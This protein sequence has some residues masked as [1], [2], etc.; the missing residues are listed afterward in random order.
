[1]VQPVVIFNWNALVDSAQLTPNLRKWL[2]LNWPTLFNQQ[3]AQLRLELEYYCKKKYGIDNIFAYS[4]MCASPQINWRQAKNSCTLGNLSGEVLIAF[5][6]LASLEFWENVPADLHYFHWIFQPKIPLSHPNNLKNLLENLIAQG[7]LVCILAESEFQG[8]VNGQYHGFITA[9]L[10]NIGLNQDSIQKMVIASSSLAHTTDESHRAF[11]F[12]QH[13]AAVV[14][15]IVEV[16]R[17]IPFCA[18]NFIYTSNDEWEVAELHKRKFRFV[19]RNP[20]YPQVVDYLNKVALEVR[21]MLHGT[22]TI[23]VPMTFYPEPCPVE[24]DPINTISHLASFSPST[25]NPLLFRAAYDQGVLAKLSPF[26]TSSMSSTP[27]STSSTSSTP[28]SPPSTPCKKT[29]FKVVDLAASSSDPKPIS[30]TSP[31]DNSRVSEWLPLDPAQLSQYMQQAFKQPL[32]RVI[33]AESEQTSSE[34][35]KKDTSNASENTKQKLRNFLY[36]NRK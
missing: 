16:N 17:H 2:T 18:E 7:V 3:Y 35:M 30:Q 11:K 29:S 8:V 33:N 4:Q 5:S 21:S 14:D 9:A 27:F 12:L 20:N 15:S 23:P 22:S 1:M 13:V 10:R 34:E 36:H 24:P 25:G 31:V 28:F 32:E 6:A 26:S 19:Y